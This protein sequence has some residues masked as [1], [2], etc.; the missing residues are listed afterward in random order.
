MSN[1]DHNNN[2]ESNL[3]QFQLNAQDDLYFQQGFEFDDLPPPPPPEEEDLDESLNNTNQLNIENS[4]QTCSDK[5]SKERTQILQNLK[6]IKSEL[7]IPT[8][9]FNINFVV[10]NTNTIQLPYEPGSSVLEFLS[11]SMLELLDHVE[12]EGFMTAD[13]VCE[14]DEIIENISIIS[15]SDYIRRCLT[16]GVVPFVSLR[17]LEEELIDNVELVMDEDVDMMNTFGTSTVQTELMISSL[18]STSGPMPT[19]PMPVETLSTSYGS[20]LTNSMKLR[21][22]EK[23]RGQIIESEKADKRRTMYLGVKDNLIASDSSNMF[24]IRLQMPGDI[25]ITLNISKSI[26]IKEL[27]KKTVEYAL[28]NHQIDMGSEEKYLLKYPGASFLINES[29]NLISLPY[30]HNCIVRGAS[31]IFVVLDK[32]SDTVKRIKRNNLEIGSLIGRPLSWVQQDDEITSF[33]QSMNRVRYFSWQDKQNNQSANELPMRSSGVMKPTGKTLVQLRLDLLQ[34]KKTV[35]APPDCTAE[36]FI[37]TNYEKYYS[38]VAPNVKFILKVAGFD[39]YIYGSN[40][41]HSFDYVKECIS[42]GKPIDLSL[43]IAPDV[44]DS[45]QDYH[46]E[47]LE[48]ETFILEDPTI[49]YDHNEITMKNKDVNDMKCISVWDIHRTYN[50]KVIGVENISHFS[51]SFVSI[52]GK[53]NSCDESKLFMYITAALYHGGEAISSTWVSS[54]VASSSNPRWYENASFDIKLS[55]LPRATR[56]CFT[57]W[58]TKKHYKTAL[59]VPLAWINFQIFDYKHEMRTGPITLN[60]WID[61]QS[62]PIGTCVQNDGEN[63]PTLYIRMEEF[64]L[65]VVFPTE[66]ISIPPYPLPS[67]VVNQEKEQL[68]KIWNSDPL[69]RMTTRDKHLMWKYREFC[70]NVPRALPRFL[71]SV[72]KANRLAIQEMYRLMKIWA[73]IKPIDALELLDAKFAD[74]KIR[75]YAVK[76]LEELSNEEI[77]DF[78]LQLVQALKYEPYHDTDFARFLLRSA[79]SDKVI[80]HHFFWYLKSEIHVPEISERFGLLL[81]AYLRGCGSHRMNL[82]RQCGL[83]QRLLTIANTI[84]TLKDSERLSTLHKELENFKLPPEGVSIPLDPRIVIKDFQI[85]KCRYMGSKKLPLWLVFNNMDSTGDSPYVLF[86][87]GDDLRQD[88][89]TLQ[90]IRIMD[91]LWK[92]ENLDL[93]LIPYGCISTGNEVGMIEV[94]QNAW[95]TAAI[96]KKAT[97][98]FREDPIDIW[99]RENNKSDQ[100]YKKAVENFMYSCAG[101]CVATYVLGIG[102]RHND[103]VMLTKDGRLFH[104]DF[105]HFLGNYK[106]KFGVKR[107]RAPFV[108][109]PDFAYVMGGKD[110]QDF[111]KFLEICCNAYNILRKHASIF[112]N[113]FAMMLSTGIPELQTSEDI[114]Y[115]RD[116]FSLDFTEQQAAQK[117]RDLVYESLTTRTTQI[118]NAIHLLVRG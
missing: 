32:T 89:L 61:D 83:Q 94:V 13:L 37:N 93:R 4:Q 11:D 117:F 21:S 66:E 54:F 78:L 72:P 107:E 45:S 46:A 6:D 55:D 29:E 91:H 56:I 112:I 43:V 39:E 12:Q 50:F 25:T 62:N 57:V 103:N 38:K 70:K 87:A 114:E 64:Q 22:Q 97:A 30:V 85:S 33:R 44:R 63:P 28:S 99:L 5:I 31:P 82:A 58:A 40:P 52:A 27:K 69:Y 84:K 19:F 79:L 88:M 104:I 59:D 47:L 71:V 98:A 16:I 110:S 76:R 41:F 100:L 113:L 116:A 109:T 8:E 75:A 14:N 1:F 24:A 81:E 118:N 49:T 67:T 3:P 86:K 23:P 95:T 26:T 36:Q 106:K 42:K 53:T 101:Y 18:T 10:S 108:F 17:P 105:G 48:D 65:P 90:M 96:T 102:D 15:E 115:L 60:M 35:I 68:E 92:H 74:S 2:F 80:G 20:P 7:V 9:P 77:V 111:Q 34:V 51:D 73:P